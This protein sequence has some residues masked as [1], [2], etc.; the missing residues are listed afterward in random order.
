MSKAMTQIELDDF[1][2]HGVVMLSSTRDDLI[3]WLEEYISGNVSALSEE[4]IEWC[5]DELIRKWNN[6]N[7]MEVLDAV[8]RIVDCADQRED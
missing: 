3:L 5:A 1:Y 8:E 4:K 7:S 2:S 6:F